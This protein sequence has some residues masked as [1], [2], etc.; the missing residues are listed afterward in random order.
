MPWYATVDA[1]ALERMKEVAA[2]A[3]DIEQD[4]ARRDVRR[5]QLRRLRGARHLLGLEAAA[6][7]I[8]VAHRAAVLPDVVGVPTLVRDH[9]TAARLRRVR[10]RP[11]T[12]TP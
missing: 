9:G 10:P 7:R 2:A 5:E 1:P 6:P 11:G 8:E 4:V 3:A 12:P